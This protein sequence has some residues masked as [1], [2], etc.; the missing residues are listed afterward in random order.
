[1]VVTAS[2]A[3]IYMQPQGGAMQSATNAVAN[4]PAAFDGVT[5]FGQDPLG[6]RFFNGSMDDVRIY[7][8]ALSAAAVGTLAADV[9]DIAPTVATPAAASPN[10]VNGPSCNLSV[11]GASA[12]GESTLTYTWAATSMP[13]GAS[14]PAFSANGTNSAQNTI[15]IFS[16]PGAYTLEANI[17]DAYGL[18]V[19]SSVNV[20]VTTAQLVW[21]GGGGNGNWSNAANW[22]EGAAA[23]RRTIGS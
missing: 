22:S 17:T 5:N 6:G 1:M 16:A 2:N 15:A 13:A 11:L 3:I 10:P 21:T 20:T 8:T 4:T 9:N 7:N 14:A 19:A 18:N 12:N 23:S